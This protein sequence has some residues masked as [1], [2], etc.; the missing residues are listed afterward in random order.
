MVTKKVLTKLNVLLPDELEGNY[1]NLNAGGCGIVAYLLAKELCKA[2]YKAEIVWLG[3]NCTEDKFNK[4]L[5][6]NNK[7]TLAEFNSEGMYL[8]HCFVKLG[9][10]YMDS[11]GV[12]KDLAN[13]GWS[14]YTAITNISW[15]TMESIALCET[16]WN[17]RFRRNQIPQIKKSVKKI[18]KNLVN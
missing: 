10:C 16:G 11:K 7:P 14:G 17:P 5:E 8:A 6:T 3:R 18:I 2:G 9:T 13:S 15:S 4:I 1:F 12:Y